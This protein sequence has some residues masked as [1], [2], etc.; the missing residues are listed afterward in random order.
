MFQYKIGEMFKE[1][2]YVFS[3]ADNILVVGYDTDSK[4]HVRT[5]GWVI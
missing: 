1:L 5:L 3:I 2:P 4:Y